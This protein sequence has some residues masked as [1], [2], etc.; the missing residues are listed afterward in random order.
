MGDVIAGVAIG[1]F[2]V[3]R[4]FPGRAFHG[5]DAYF[6]IIL[7]SAIGKI[8]EAIVVDLLLI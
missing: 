7:R 1:G 8:P 3:G 6:P 5:A 2:Q 4:I